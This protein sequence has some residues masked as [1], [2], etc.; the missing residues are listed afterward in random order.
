VAACVTPNVPFYD[1]FMGVTLGVTGMLA[2]LF[3]LWLIGTAIAHLRALPH[4]RRV[5]FNRTV[6]SRLILLLILCCACF[7]LCCART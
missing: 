6:T 3:L 1:A 7:P 5:S 2:Y 4:A